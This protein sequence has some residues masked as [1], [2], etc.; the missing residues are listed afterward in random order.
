MKGYLN[1]WKAKLNTC[2][3]GEGGAKVEKEPGNTSKAKQGHQYCAVWLT[4]CFISGVCGAAADELL[5]LVERQLCKP[6]EKHYLLPNMR[7]CYHAIYFSL[8]KYCVCIILMEIILQTHTII[9][10]PHVCVSMPNK[11]D[12]DLYDD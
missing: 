8:S 12:D 2:A 3:E 7:N 11:Y 10:I 4:G 6:Q 1:A 5:L 9:N